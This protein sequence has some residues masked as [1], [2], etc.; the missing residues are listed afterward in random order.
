MMESFGQMLRRL[1]EAR[2]MLT[3]LQHGN[4]SSNLCERQLSQNELANRAGFDP[5]L[6]N[7]LEAGKGWHPKRETVERLAEALQLDDVSTCRLLITAG[8]WPWDFDDDMIE[9]IFRA[10][11]RENEGRAIRLEGTG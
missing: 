2:T 3:P 9:A 4:P 8:Y 11:R 7:K 6:V 5:A 1:R 10:V